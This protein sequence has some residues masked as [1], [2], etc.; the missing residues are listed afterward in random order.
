MYTSFSDREPCC[1]ASLAVGGRDSSRGAVLA[2]E[3]SDYSAP[4]RPQST[5][6]TGEAVRSRRAL[7]QND[8]FAALVGGLVADAGEVVVL[9]VDASSP[10]LRASA[11]LVS[12]LQRAWRADCESAFAGEIEQRDRCGWAHPGGAS[13]WADR[14][15]RPLAGIGLGQRSGEVG[16]EVEDAAALRI[17]SRA[18]V[19][20]TH[21]RV[22]AGERSECARRHT[23]VVGLLV[24]DTDHWLGL[25]PLPA[26]WIHRQPRRRIAKLGYHAA[27]VSAWSASSTRSRPPRRV[28][29]CAGVRPSRSGEGEVAQCVS[30]SAPPG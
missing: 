30:D 26:G 12:P 11:W 15:L 2:R 29:V 3:R 17:R 24:I 8:A 1:A 23:V 9:L 5:V 14:Y 19:G 22:E 25:Q 27:G 6:A 18:P 28:R 7:P 16:C 13:V 20:V 10:A 21:V 4:H